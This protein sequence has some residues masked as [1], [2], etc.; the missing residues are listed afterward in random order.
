M[1]VHRNS[2]RARFRVAVDGRGLTSHS[3]TAALRELA[4]RI[5]L[6]DALSAAAAPV[7]SIGLVHEPGAVLRDLVV[8]LADGGDDFSAIETLRGQTDVDG[9]VASDST[10]W[11]RVADLAGHELSVARL[12]GARKRVRATVWRLGGAPPAVDARSGLMCIDVDATLVTAHSDKES[13]AGSTPPH[14]SHQRR[15]CIPRCLR[16]SSDATAGP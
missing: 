11:R 1:R 16:R 14:P 6:T 10:A 7:S 15:C 9:P 13:A 8:M 2:R 4:D 3:G 5:G 12:D